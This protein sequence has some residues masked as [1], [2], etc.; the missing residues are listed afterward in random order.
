MFQIESTKILISQNHSL[1]HF[2]IVSAHVGRITFSIAGPPMLS[3][4][5]AIQ[6]SYTAKFYWN[7]TYVVF[8]KNWR[9]A[10]ITDIPWTIDA[11]VPCIHDMAWVVYIYIS[12]RAGLK[13]NYE[14]IWDCKTLDNLFFSTSP[15][16]HTLDVK[17]MW[18]YLFTRGQFWPPGI[19]VACVCQSVRPSV[20]KFVRAI[21][22]RPFQLGSPN[23]N[24]R[25]K[26]P[27]LRSTLFFGVIDSDLSG[28][29]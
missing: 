14:F 8:N 23:I 29:I 19:V 9:S 15:E 20:T 1:N 11:W 18:L 13:I 26:R 7:N 21:T 25:C 5:L 12:N 27:W 4:W 16:R 10:V 2:V 17:N 3:H 28:N 6:T 24:H 22:H